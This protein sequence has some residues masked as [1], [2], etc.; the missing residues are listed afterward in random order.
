MSGGHP[1]IPF[2]AT[3]RK[4]NS[5]IFIGNLKTEAT[6]PEEIVSIFSKYGNIIEEPVFRRSFGFVQFDNER[7]A[8]E[9]IAS[10]NGR[11]VA[12]MPIGMV[13]T[14]LFTLL[15]CFSKK[16]IL[17]IFLHLFLETK[18]ADIRV[19]TPNDNRENNRDNRDR[20]VRD[21]RDNH[22]DNRDQRDNRDRQSDHNRDRR[23]DSNDGRH[24]GHENRGNFRDDYNHNNNRHEQFNDGGR[25]QGYGNNSHYSNNNDRDE[26]HNNNNNNRN[27]YDDQRENIT[28]H[29]RRRS[30]SPPNRVR[31]DWNRDSKRMAGNNNNNNSSYNHNQGGNMNNGNVQNNNNNGRAEPPS[32]QFISESADI[33]L[34][35]VLF[36]AEVSL[37]TSTR[38]VS[39]SFAYSRFPA[40]F[41]IIVLILILYQ[42]LHVQ[43]GETVR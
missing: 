3:N 42:K 30:P 8:A 10:E 43:A 39:M 20:N 38:S 9:A 11:I 40:I 15:F 7:S 31:D 28:G 16:L 19:R 23:F 21:Q 35:V 36:H 25:G 33:K 34:Y 12:G 4:E 13:S 24:G 37:S 27:N 26:Y 6:T 32:C 22:R 14:S 18:K 41:S 5:R 17:F 2:S 1:R 29:R